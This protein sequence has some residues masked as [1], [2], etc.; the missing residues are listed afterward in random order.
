MEE[1]EVQKVKEK[2]AYQR[3]CEEVKKRSDDYQEEVRRQKE[4]V[5][6]QRKAYAETLEAQVLSYS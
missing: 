4:E 3:Y 1:K 6:R 2:E 5:A